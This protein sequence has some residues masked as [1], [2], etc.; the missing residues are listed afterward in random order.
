MPDTPRDSADTDHKTT[1]DIAAPQA[2]CDFWFETLSAKQWFAKDAALDGEIAERFG[3]TLAAAARCELWHWRDSPTGRVAE[4]VVL[5]QFS[6][7][8]HRDTPAAFAQDP[9]AL[10]LAQELIARGEDTALPLA[11]RIFAYMPFM[12]SESLAIHAR[13]VTLFDTPGM[14]AQLDY[15]HRHREIIQ[16]FGRYPHRNAILGRVSTPEEIAFLRQPGSAF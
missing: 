8:V 1:G 2:V 5:D 13:A 3:A 7:N 15:E 16:R 10:A 14:E 11:Q 6:R 4:I 9:L 12:H